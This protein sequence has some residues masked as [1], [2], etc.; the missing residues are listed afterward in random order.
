MSGIELFHEFRRR[1]LHYLLLLA[2]VFIAASCFANKLYHTLALPLLQQLPHPNGM[3]AIGIATPLLIPLKS[4]FAIALYV[5]IPYLLLQL[6]RFIA[7][8]LYP[9]EKRF[10]WWMLGS[11]I[12]LFYL[13]TL[14]AYWVTLPLVFQFFV[15]ITPAGIELKPDISLY[16]SFVMRL[17]FAF[18]FSF[19]VP[20]VIV[21]LVKTSI[22]SYDQIASKRPYCIVM[23]FIVGMVLT[24]PD[25]I[26][27]LLL[28]LPLWG[29]YEIGL[30]IC[31]FTPLHRTQSTNESP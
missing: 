4:A 15:A 14:F 25:V 12:M 27:Q 18:G 3:I 23:A 31:R 16:F 20:I 1:M 17:L 30:L 13:G 8:A 28:A 26:S 2:L 6:W 19:E 5:T 29:L 7:P 21:A 11:S 10:A 24:P 9:Q 22:C